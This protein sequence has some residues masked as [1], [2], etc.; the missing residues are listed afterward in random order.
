MSGATGK[1]SFSFNLILIN[2]NLNSH[3][4]LKATIILDRVTRRSLV[5]FLISFVYKPGK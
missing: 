4:W 2:L 3:V 1:L 5:V